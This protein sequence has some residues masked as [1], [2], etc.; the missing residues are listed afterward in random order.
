[1]FNRFSRGT[2]LLF[3]LDLNRE[4]AHGKNMS[5]TTHH[6]LYI[7]LSYQWIVIEYN[8]IKRTM[9]FIS[10]LFSYWI[11]IDCSIYDSYGPTCYVLEPIQFIWGLSPPIHFILLDNSLLYHRIHFNSSSP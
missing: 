10:I 8:N 6:I 5:S 7:L 3:I 11:D 4:L 1:M 9:L 2:K